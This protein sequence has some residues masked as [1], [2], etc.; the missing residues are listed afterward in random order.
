LLDIL[1]VL[2]DHVDKQDMGRQRDALRWPA[3]VER[4]WINTWPPSRREF[5]QA[6]S[7]IPWLD[8]RSV[9]RVIVLADDRVQPAA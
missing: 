1:A 2:F 6:I 9:R 4:G 5:G 3:W 7:A 8:D